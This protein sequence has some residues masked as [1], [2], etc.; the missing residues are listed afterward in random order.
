MNGKMMKME[1]SVLL[2]IS[3]ICDIA[4]EQPLKLTISL[5]VTT[6]LHETVDLLNAAVNV[7]ISE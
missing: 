5:Y 3:T 4:S 2:A 1:H 6:G 7:D